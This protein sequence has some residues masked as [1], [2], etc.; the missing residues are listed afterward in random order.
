MCVSVTNST[1]YQGETLE[2]R[3]SP[4]SLWYWFLWRLRALCNSLHNCLQR[5]HCSHAG[6]MEVPHAA[7]VFDVFFKDFSMFCRDFF[8]SSRLLQVIVILAMCARKL[9]G[10]AASQGFVDVPSR[11]RSIVQ[12]VENRAA[13]SELRLHRRSSRVYF[14]R[15]HW[16]ISGEVH[17]TVRVH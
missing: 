13:A 15:S 2:L 9:V 10:K 3:E 1:R 4:P 8:C 5:K 11:I 16:R 17:K 6:T 12:K 7:T 14:Y